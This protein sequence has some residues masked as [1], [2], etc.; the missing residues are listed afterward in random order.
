MEVAGGGGMGSRACR[1]AYG[2]GR[3]VVMGG[4][5][6]G[7]EGKKPGTPVGVLG[8]DRS[9]PAKKGD[10]LEGT[11]ESDLGRDRASKT[12]VEPDARHPLQGT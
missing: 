6:C 7:P 5:S 8:R 2:S 4:A 11:T 1:R 3:D 9:G 10:G 12:Q